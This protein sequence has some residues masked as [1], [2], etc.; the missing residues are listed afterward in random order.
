MKKIL[1][2]IIICLLFACSKTTNHPAVINPPTPAPPT[3][4]TTDGNN[5][6][7]DSINI[8]IVCSSCNGSS[9]DSFAVM[10][11][12]YYPKPKIEFSGG[13]SFWVLRNQAATITIY[14]HLGTRVATV[15][16]NKIKMDDWHDVHFDAFVQRKD[17]AV[18]SSIPLDSLTNIVL[19]GNF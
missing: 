14:V 18:F 11:Q 3:I 8:G 12:M 6:K 4:I 5:I 2:P 15:W 13:Q 10:N 9:V 19:Y 17:S 7:G 1:T 16:L